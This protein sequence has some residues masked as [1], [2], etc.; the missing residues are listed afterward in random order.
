MTVPSQLD[1]A[2]DAVDALVAVEPPG[3]GTGE[4]Y[5]SRA[6]R[7][8]VVAPEAARALRAAVAARL[9]VE[10]YVPGRTRTRIH[11]IYFDTA[12]FALYRRSLAPGPAPGLKLRLRAYGDARTPDRPDAARFLEAKLGVTSPDGPRLK[13]KARLALSDRKLARLMKAKGTKR[14]LSRRK[15]WQPLL[16]YLAAFQVRPRLTVSYEREAF[17][18]RAGLLRVTFDE[19]YHASVVEGAASPLGAPVG[20]LGDAVIVE[21]KFVQ[22]LPP[23]L[24]DELVRLGLPPEGQPFSKFKTAV[25]LLFPAVAPEPPGA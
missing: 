18:D 14:P 3:A 2:F 12:D 6:E 21:I 9:D 16:A 25:P 24:V 8:L 4:L 19:G 5:A 13:R 17:V 15:F 23:W 10:Q 7:K 1:P 22:A 11:S 20:R